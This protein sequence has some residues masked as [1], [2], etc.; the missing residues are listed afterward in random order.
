MF[1]YHNFKG[2]KNLKSQIQNY[3]HFLLNNL[4]AEVQNAKLYIYI[5]RR[6]YQIV[7]LVLHTCFIFIIRRF[8]MNISL[9]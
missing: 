4:S 8:L 5:F 3:S 2:N 1:L 7:I 9:Y 6:K